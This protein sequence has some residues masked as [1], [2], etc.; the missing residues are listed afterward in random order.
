MVTLFIIAFIAGINIFVFFTNENL[1]RECKSL[2]LKAIYGE[3]PFLFLKFKGYVSLFLINYLMTFGLLSMLLFVNS[4]KTTFIFAITILP[5]A[6]FAIMHR[7]Y[8]SKINNFRL[9]LCQVIIILLSFGLCMKEYFWLKT[10]SIPLTYELFYF[11]FIILL[12]FLLIIITFVNLI[13]IY[14]NRSEMNKQI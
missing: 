10:T 14:C 5:F 12:L 9:C 1:L 7:P 6:S 3:I 8:R 11:L 4:P 13:I 2:L